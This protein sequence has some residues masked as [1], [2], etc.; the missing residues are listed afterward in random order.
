MYVILGAAGKV[1]QTTATALRQASLPV[2]AVVRDA[3]QGAALA[4]IG[5]EVV[6]AD[7]HDQSALDRAL[8]GAQAVQVLVPLPRDDAHPADTM[9]KTIDVTARVLALSDYGAELDADTG[10]TKLF[11]HLEA[12][13][14]EVSPKLTLLR[15][16]EHMQNWAR[17]LPVAL[18]SGVLPSFHDPVDK[19]FPTISAGD[20][21]VVSARLLRDGPSAAAMRVVSVEGPARVTAND[22]AQSIEKASGRPVKALALPRDQWASVLAQG[23]ASEQ[24]AQLIIDL[25]EA[26]NAGRID[27][28][29]D[30]GERAFGTTSLDSAVAAMVASAN[31]R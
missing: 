31:G 2:R 16:A 14:R 30:A 25:F 1:G 11:H 13:L 6:F 12:A 9:R 21:G 29:A 22:V 27:V 20:V 24:H 28:E 15:S 18:S 17:V 4:S 7:L 26:H 5:C 23:G 3:V 19:R 10:I 8:D